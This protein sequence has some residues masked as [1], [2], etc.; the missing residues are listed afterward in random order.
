LQAL[1]ADGYQGLYTIE[2]HYT[3]EGGTPMDGTRMAVERLRE[4]LE[5]ETSHEEQ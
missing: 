3:P 4:L 2:T 5:Q 1:E